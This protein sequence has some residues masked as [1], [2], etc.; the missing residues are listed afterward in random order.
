MKL[1]KRQFLWLPHLVWKL[2]LNEATINLVLLAAL[3]Q[4][5]CQPTNWLLLAALEQFKC[6]PTNWLLLAALEEYKDSGTAQ[7]EDIKKTPPK[8]LPLQYQWLVLCQ[9]AT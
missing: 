3:E 2:V 4:F 7:K 5:K 9:V 1:N 6:Q 8:M